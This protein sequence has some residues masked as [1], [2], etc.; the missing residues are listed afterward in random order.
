MDRQ[1]LRN[2]I[3]TLDGVEVKGKENLDKLLGCINA[4]ESMLK[5]EDIQQQKECEEMDNGR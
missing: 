5:V 2:I 1:L 3:H 4:L